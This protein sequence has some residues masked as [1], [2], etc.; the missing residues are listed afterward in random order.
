VQRPGN[1]LIWVRAEI[2]EGPITPNV[3]DRGGGAS[4]YCASRRW[5]VARS[6][7]SLAASRVWFGAA[8]AYQCC[9]AAVQ[10]LDPE[11]AYTINTCYGPYTYSFM[12]ISLLTISCP[13]KSSITLPI[14]E[15][16]PSLHRTPN[17]PSTHS[18]LR[19][20]LPT[21]RALIPFRQQVLHF[22]GPSPPNSCTNPLSAHK[23]ALYLLSR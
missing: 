14:L 12:V 21:T 15:S 20:P 6:W 2:G 18:P 3:A 13:Y 19:D 22:Q 7:Q 11:I 23:S 17:H 8:V 16:A 10:I 4:W 1:C 5:L 9:S